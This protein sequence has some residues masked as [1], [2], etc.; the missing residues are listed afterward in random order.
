MS[1]TPRRVAICGRSTRVGANANDEIALHATEHSVASQPDGINAMGWYSAAPPVLLAGQATRLLTDNIGRLDVVVAGGGAFATHDL[2]HI[3]IGPQIMA[4]YNAVPAAVNDGDAVRVQ[5]TAEGYL[6]SRARDATRPWLWAEQGV[7]QVAIGPAMM[8]AYNQAPAPVTNGQNVR[9]QSDSRGRIETAAN[10]RA[11]GGDMDFEQAPIE[12][13]FGSGWSFV[14][15]ALAAQGAWS[16]AFEQYTL[17]RRYLLLLFT[18][19]R[20]I[21]NGAF[22]GRIEACITVANTDT[23]GYAAMVTSGPVT[24][25]EDSAVQM[26]RTRPYR[27]DS[28]SGDAETSYAIYDLGRAP[29]WR[30]SFR[31]N[32]VQ[33]TPGTLGVKY[34]LF[35]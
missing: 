22:E 15:A 23:W 26:Q 20:G 11:L 8:A 4:D 30:T 25:S 32:G 1:D 18:Y 24:P 19:T 6:W 34:H 2:P 16:T 29:K 5:A 17:N 28:T 35:N 33:A 27:Y 12:L 13:D 21:L 14:T 31:E 7:A 9:A 10:N 3:A